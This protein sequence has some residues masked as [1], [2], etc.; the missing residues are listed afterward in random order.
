MEYYQSQGANS[1]MFPPPSFHLP[2]PSSSNHPKNTHEFQIKNRG[3]VINSHPP[4]PNESLL[5]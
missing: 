2:I 4:F 5:D 1:L 3:S